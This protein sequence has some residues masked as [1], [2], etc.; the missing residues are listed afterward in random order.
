MTDAILRLVNCFPSAGVAATGLL[1]F[2]G[3]VPQTGM[4]ASGN[5]H[6]GSPPHLKLSAVCTPRAQ[7]AQRWLT[8]ELKGVQQQQH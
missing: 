6:A 1:L 4:H 3:L 7:W 2:C 8:G 5:R